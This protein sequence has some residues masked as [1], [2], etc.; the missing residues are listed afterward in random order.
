MYHWPASANHTGVSPGGLP[1]A[2]NTGT[3]PKTAIQSWQLGPDGPGWPA[4]AP[5]APVSPVPTGVATTGVTAVGWPL[6]PA[7]PPVPPVPPVSSGARSPPVVR[8]GEVAVG[9]GTDVTVT[10]RNGVSVAVAKP[11]VAVRTTVGVAQGVCVS[12]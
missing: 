7:V 8:M 12:D 11:G 10:V 4:P 5:G 6:V 3:M 1:V 9:Q 2:E